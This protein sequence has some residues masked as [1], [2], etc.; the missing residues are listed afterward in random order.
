[1]N[2]ILDKINLKNKF[3]FLIIVPFFGFLFMSSLY[4]NQI[5]KEPSQNGLTFAIGFVLVIFFLTVFMFIIITNNINNS[6]VTIKTGLNRFFNYLTSTEKNLDPIDL[7]SNDDFADMAKELNSNIKKIKD[8]LAI[9]NEVIN[10]AK[11]VSQMIGKGFLVYR[12]GKEANNVYINELKDNIN[13][14]IDSLRE[15]IVNSFLTSLI[16]YLLGHNFWFLLLSL[17]YFLLLLMYLLYL[18]LSLEQQHLFALKKLP[19]S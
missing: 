1:M 15:N 16:L 9:D 17:A 4:I 19:D 3:I 2:K 14:M 8:G 13:H 6:I 18:K 11:F 7:N 5:L 10:E 12:I